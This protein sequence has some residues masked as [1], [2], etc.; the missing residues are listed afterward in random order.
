MTRDFPSCTAERSAIQNY[1]WLNWLTIRSKAYKFEEFEEWTYCILSSSIIPRTREEPLPGSFG[2]KSTASRLLSMQSKRQSY[3]QYNMRH[4]LET[5]CYKNVQL[6]C[7][8]VWSLKECHLLGWLQ[9]FRVCF[10]FARWLPA[11][12]LYMYMY[13][14]NHIKWHAS[15]DQAGSYT[16]SN[17]S[18]VN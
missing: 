11:D 16:Y 2:N 5:L 15:R 4:I 12:I 13:D 1:R 18:R 14:Q 3:F 10:K 7:T 17:F 9:Y 6:K 8:S